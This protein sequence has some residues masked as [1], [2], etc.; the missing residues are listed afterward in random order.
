MDKLNT[1]RIAGFLVVAL[2]TTWALIAL[3]MANPSPPSAAAEPCPD[4]EVVFAR[5]T[6]E[7]PGVGATGQV[8]VDSLRAEAGGRSVGVYPVNYPATNDF[9]S[10]I[11]NGASD[12]SD[13]VQSTAANCPNTKVVLGGFSQG[14]SV[15]DAVTQTMPPAVADHVAA[16]VVF[17]TPRS[18]YAA[19][20]GGGAPLPVM[21]PLYASKTI[22]QCVHD[23]PI[24]SE[25]FNALAF[26]AHDSYRF[27]G[28]ANDAAKFAAG[29]L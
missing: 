29:R 1:R 19:S 5:G 8:F 25:P 24:C 3:A 20:L 15:V 10:S 22:D 28:M 21:S 14:A 6:T 27:N 18:A 17:G 16:V 11:A 9:A 23:D 12:A 7:A 2:A 4:V 26:F 13:H